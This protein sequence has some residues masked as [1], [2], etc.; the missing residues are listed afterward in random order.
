MHYYAAAEIEAENA[1]KTGDVQR[2]ESQEH[3]I[4]HTNTPHWQLV[5]EA[6]HRKAQSFSHHG[7][8]VE[9]FLCALICVFE[10]ERKA[11]ESPYLCGKDQQ[12]YNQPS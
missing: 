6:N 9:T 2:K 8:E 12:I 3:G 1:S 11:A 4:T 10:Q 5:Q 7:E